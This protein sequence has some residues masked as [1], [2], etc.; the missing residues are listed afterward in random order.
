MSS[1]K[2]TTV[3]VT[4]AA[5]GIGA[6][7]AETFST[8]GASVFLTDID[9]VAGE[10]MT[11]GLR[12]RGL[13]AHYKHL[14]VSN[15]DEWE[16]VIQTITSESGLDVLVNNAG[17]TMGGSLETT[18]FDSWRVIMEVNLDGTFLGIKHGILAMKKQGGIIIN[19]GSITGQQAFTFV[20]PTA[21]SKAG[22]RSLTKTAALECSRL[23][24]NI[25]VNSINPGAVETGLW[26][27]QGWSSSSSYKDHEA[28]AREEI[29]SEIPLNRFSSPSEIASCALFLASPEA[30]YVHGAEL[31]VDG[32]VTAGHHKGQLNPHDT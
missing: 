25:R 16:T 19:I 17:V 29:L 10:E 18:D 31:N 4:G 8:A 28:Q 27:E 12:N 22:V 7:I 23:G 14:D 1:F 30:S 5:T 3:L 6:A 24:Y 13:E 26:T 21:A 9:D 15:E 11:A 20:G 2:G 32:G